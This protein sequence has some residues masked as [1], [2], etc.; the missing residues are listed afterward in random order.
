VTFAPIA[1]PSQ[2]PNYA[3][4]LK[5]PGITFSDDA[6]QGYAAII[7]TAEL[8]PASLGSANNP[9]ITVPTTNH[10][11]EGHIVSVEPRT[12]MVLTVFRPESRHN[13]IFATERCNSNCLMCSQP[14]KDVDDAW[15]VKEHLR[16]LSLIEEAP[17]FL[18]ITGGE[19]TLMGNGLIQVLTEIR[20]RFP[21]T[22]IQ[23]LTNG[24]T[25]KDAAVPQRIASVGN[26]QLVSAIPLYSDIAGIHD[27]IVQAEG[28]FDET[29]EGLYNAAEA[30]LVVEIRVVLH[31][32]SIP[33]LKQLAE[34]IYHNFPFAAHVTFMGMEHQG[35]V[36]KN[37]DLLWVDPVDYMPMLEEAVQYLWQRRMTVSIYNLQLC[38]LPRSLWHVGRKSISDFKNEYVEEC[39]GC[40]Q[41]D[42]CAG[43]FTSQVNRY[44]QYLRRL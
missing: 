4:V 40:T 37:W 34:Y 9:V 20:D 28:A 6:A 24:R 1:D 44:S 32:Q 17:Q 41:R 14:P 12:G 36:K 33:R 2:R 21:T 23:M 38:L 15:R 10:F 25:Y 35:Y 31:K 43:L 22:S 7:S 5:E 27:Y 8:K 19:P 18:C 42:H 16:V 39:Q 29:V 26:R 30:G 13:V 11:A 3:L